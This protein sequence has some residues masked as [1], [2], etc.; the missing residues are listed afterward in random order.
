MALRPLDLMEPEETVGNIWHDL[1]TKPDGALA[2]PDAVVAL[3]QLRTSLLFLFRALGGA[4]SVEIA[5]A[6]LTRSQHRIGARLKVGNADVR[7][8][9]ASFD[10]ERLLLPPEIASF[11]D[12]KLNRTTYLWLAAS[13]A[14]SDTPEFPDD[15]IAAD[16]LQVTANARVAE[17]VYDRCPG[18]RQSYDS[19]R[20]ATLKSRA[21]VRRPQ[22]RGQS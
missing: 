21:E 20:K 9:K 14:L 13:A 6:P 1:V 7:L 3:D 12:A 4:G 16:W 17:A 10:G 2:Y 19:L 22:T 11:P 5:P 18:L 8:H 15:R